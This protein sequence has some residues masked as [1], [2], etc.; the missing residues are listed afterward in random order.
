MN[1]AEQ[2]W[3]DVRKYLRENAIPDGAVLLPNDE[4]LAWEGALHVASDADGTWTLC[5]VDYGQPRLLLRRATRP[6]IVQA[7]YAYVLT[8]IPEA[9]I[10]ATHE[11][12]RMLTWA[13]PH[14]ND[15]AARVGNGLIIDVP[16]GLLLDRIG[17]IDGYLLY[18]AGTSFEARSLPVNTV[19]Q[20]LQTLATASTIRMKVTSTPPWFGRPGGGLR[21]A[22]VEPGIGIRDLVREG[23]LTQIA[24]PAKATPG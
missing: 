3:S 5:T 4:Q 11:I 12:E 8:P 10:L 14:L 18:P 20:P 6:E 23:Q 24:V 7:L 15:I 22:I 17:A 1:I 21:F 16:A 9:V 19:R 13:T 2:S